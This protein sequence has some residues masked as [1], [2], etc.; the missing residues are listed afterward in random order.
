MI[1]WHWSTIIKVTALTA[2][3]GV[4]SAVLVFYLWL[5]VILV[6]CYPTQSCP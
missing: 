3:F 2:L 4:V 6:H 5:A 1:R